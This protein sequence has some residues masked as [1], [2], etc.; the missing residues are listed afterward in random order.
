MVA[1]REVPAVP[2]DPSSGDLVGRVENCLEKAEV[3]GASTVANARLVS[4]AVLSEAS[5]TQLLLV[6]PQQKRGVD[7]SNRECRATCLEV[8]SLVRLAAACEGRANMEGQQ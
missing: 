1:L 8:A 7:S 6:T 2:F 3:D 5:C 4:T